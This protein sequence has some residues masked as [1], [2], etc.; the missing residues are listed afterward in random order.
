MFFAIEKTS[1]LLGNKARDI[2]AMLCSSSASSVCMLRAPTGSGDETRNP[3]A[4]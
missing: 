1:R 4:G 2:T 3:M